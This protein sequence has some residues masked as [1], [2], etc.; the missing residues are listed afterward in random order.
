MSLG[1]FFLGGGVSPTSQMTSVRAPGM[2]AEVSSPGLGTL[3]GES[4]GKAHDKVPG[5]LAQA[6]EI[7][8]AFARSPEEKKSFPLRLQVYRP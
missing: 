2:K 5:T 8:D 4:R 3:L 6:S 7:K 1:C